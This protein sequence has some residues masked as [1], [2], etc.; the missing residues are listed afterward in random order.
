MK[1]TAKKPLALIV[2]MCMIAALLITGPM[3]ITA[4]GASTGGGSTSGDGGST[5]PPAGGIS[6]ERIEELNKID[7]SGAKSVGDI[8]QIFEQNNITD[9]SEKNVVIENKLLNFTNITTSAGNNSM[10]NNGS[11]TIVVQNPVYVTNITFDSSNLA[12]LLLSLAS[13]NSSVGN[14][15]KNVVANPVI[16][17]ASVDVT[18]SAAPLNLSVNSLAAGESTVKIEWSDATGTLTYKKEY[19]VVNSN[20]TVESRGVG[21]DYI[22]GGGY[23][24]GGGGSGSTATAGL[25]SSTVGGSGAGGAGG[26]G[27]GATGGGDFNPNTGAKDVISVVS[28]FGVASLMAGAFVA[29][30]KSRK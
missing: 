13:R 30:K 14:V 24:P 25:D 18:G 28:A 26:T 17:A 8:T 29:V 11:G 1:S 23:M 9:Q 6:N 21:G 16:K 4:A 20:R 2:L 3:S 27:S 22:A 10:I 12:S 7:I 15:G 19:E 5:P